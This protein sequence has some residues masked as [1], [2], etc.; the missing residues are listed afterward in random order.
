MRKRPLTAWNK[1]GSRSLT[2]MLGDVPL[3]HA[4]IPDKYTK[5]IVTSARVRKDLE[6]CIASFNRAL[7]TLMDVHNSD[8]DISSMNEKFPEE[9]VRFQAFLSCGFVSYGR[10]FVDS[11]VDHKRL[12]SEE[13]G[14]RFVE[15]HQWAMEVMRNGYYA[16]TGVNM[17]DDPVIAATFLHANGQ[18]F[19]GLVSDINYSFIF[20]DEMVLNMLEMAEF[21]YAYINRR[22][23][24]QLE[25]LHKML[26]EKNM[27][28]EL[29][30][31]AVYAT[32]LPCHAPPP[33]LPPQIDRA[34]R[35][36]GIA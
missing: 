13:E 22:L 8:G 1:D 15:L 18:S 36:T 9:I 33:K 5:K 16:H 28:S 23:L 31:S 35:D 27:M 2:F 26:I 7:S 4:R 32:R 30:A 34:C 11:Y 21:A 12:Y 20:E 3:L 17:F 25:A 14:E 6:V 29:A 24:D 19:T 10:V